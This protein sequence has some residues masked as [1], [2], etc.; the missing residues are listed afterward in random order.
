VTIS[1]LERGTQEPAWPSGR[2]LAKALGLTCAAFETGEEEVLTA[3]LP[4][5]R[6]LGRPK[7][8]AGDA[9]P[10]AKGRKTRKHKEK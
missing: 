10:A 1:M 5:P 6:P 9:K 2:A 3:P 4:P 7:K 8:D